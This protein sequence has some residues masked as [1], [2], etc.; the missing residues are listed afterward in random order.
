MKKEEAIEQL[1]DS[2][3][4]LYYYIRLNRRSETI[5]VVKNVGSSFKEG[6]SIE[7]LPMHFST[8]WLIDLLTQKENG[9][10][11]TELSNLV[12]WKHPLKERKRFGEKVL[13]PLEAAGFITRTER[14]EKN[15]RSIL[16]KLTEEGVK[17]LSILKQ[18]RRENI[19][20]LLALLNLKSEEECEKF[21]VAFNEIA[22]RAWLTIKAETNS[23]EINQESTCST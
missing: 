6:E 11:G 23:K 3:P 19:E 10:I 5:T 7:L 2:F 16:I 8:L 21:A 15:R 13:D 12:L 9:C 1:S 14:P 17:F 4:L 20:K 22:E 18:T